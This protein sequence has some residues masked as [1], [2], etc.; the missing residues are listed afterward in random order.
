MKYR[1]GWRS[2]ELEFLRDICASADDQL[3]TRGELRNPR[4]LRKEHR[5]VLRHAGNAVVKALLC[6]SIED[7]GFNP[8]VLRIQQLS[9]I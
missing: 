2:Y 4:R 6:S 1:V 5:P 9:H 3:I 7:S 8:V